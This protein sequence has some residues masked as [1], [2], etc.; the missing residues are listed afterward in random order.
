M[1]RTQGVVLGFYGVA[2]SGLLVLLVLAP[3]EPV[4]RDRRWLRVVL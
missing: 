3:D 1:N 4:A 2:W